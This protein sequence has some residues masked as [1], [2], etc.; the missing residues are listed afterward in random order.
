MNNF[1]KKRYNIIMQKIYLVLFLLIFTCH[2]SI[3]ASV[4]IFDAEGFRLG[5]CTENGEIYEAHDLEGN[6]ILKDAKNN[7][8][9]GK[10]L[11]FYD[12][13]GNLIKFSNEKR[14]IAPVNFE[15]DGKLYKGPLY[16]RPR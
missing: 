10:V 12:R 16:R 15:I 6:P 1:L 2:T 8:V 7:D 14:T 3:E 13:N 11:Y 9:P 5:T 4:K